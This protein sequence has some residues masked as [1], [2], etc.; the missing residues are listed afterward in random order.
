[1]TR[2]FKAI[3]QLKALLMQLGARGG[4]EGGGGSTASWEALTSSSTRTQGM[5]QSNSSTQQILL[6]AIRHSQVSRLCFNKTHDGPERER[7]PNRLVHVEIELLADGEELG[8]KGLVDFNQIHVGQTE[9]G[10][11]ESLLDGSAK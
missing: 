8:G 6:Q 1:M 10:A 7:W 2:R 3:V 11:G 9:V 4:M 5:T